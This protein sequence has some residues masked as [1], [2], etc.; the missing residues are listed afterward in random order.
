MTEVPSNIESLRVFLDKHPEHKPTIPKGPGLGLGGRMG[1]VAAA[2]AMMAI[3]KLGITASAVQ[4]SVYR[5]LR[6]DFVGN[7]EIFVE[8]AGI[9]DVLLGH[10]GMSICGQFLQAVQERIRRNITVAYVADAD[11]IPLYSDSDE[12]LRTF[13]KLIEEARDRTFFTIDPHFCV[14]SLA[15]TPEDMFATAINATVK[16]ATAISKIKDN[17]PYVIEFSVDECGRITSADELKYLVEELSRRKVILFSVA[18]S[19]GFDKKDSD[20]PEIRE[21]L[22]K[23]LPVFNSIAKDNGLVLGIHSGDGKSDDTL[24]VI[25]EATDGNVWYRIS[26]DR[27]RIFFKLLANSPKDSPE[28]KLFEDM[29]EKLLIIVKAGTGSED[30][31]FAENC[32]NGL[33]EFE[34]LHQAKPNADCRI[35]FDFGFLLVKEFKARL[36]GIGEDF[37]KRYFE[38]DFDYIRNL[39]DRVGLL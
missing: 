21:N 6:P 16:A 9:G 23:L 22:R 19:V 28:R 30:T 8:Y 36:D 11:H 4:S 35:F 27:Q 5:E 25:G 17:G 33:A 37:A 7:E 29:F 39:A 34:M 13:T 15:K 12:D 10:T 38:A 2:A 31:E 24:G 32:R 26:P 14:N 3:E 1:S 18:P 20:G